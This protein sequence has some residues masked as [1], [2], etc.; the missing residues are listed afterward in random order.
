MFMYTLAA[1]LRQG[2]WRLRGRRMGAARPDPVAA[3]ADRLA[4]PGHSF[5]LYSNL[6]M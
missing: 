2:R 1:G 4:E 3:E 6:F 5:V